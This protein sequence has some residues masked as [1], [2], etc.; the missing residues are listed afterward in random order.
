MQAM[1]TSNILEGWIL[2]YIR[3]KCCKV[4]HGNH[5][6]NRSLQGYTHQNIPMYLEMDSD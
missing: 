4:Q 2:T 3:K 1:V 6:T 5:I